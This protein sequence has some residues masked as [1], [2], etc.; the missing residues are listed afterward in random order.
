MAI[1][2]NSCI[3]CGACTVA[4][5]AENN[6]PVVG[7]TEV[8]RVHEMSWI[9]ID[10]YYSF[11]SEHGTID[12]EKE[13]DNIED[14][15]DI[16]VVFQPMLCQHC[17]NA[18]CENVCPV[19]ATNHSS[20]GPESNGL[21]TVVSERGIAQITVLIKCVGSTGWIIPLL[22]YSLGTNLGR[23]QLLESKTPA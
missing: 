8:M 13:Y 16:Q 3:G 7:K 14:Y 18:P 23:C 9:R 20:E 22:T 6:V 4:C 15:Q 19:N 11:Q 10:R 2:L 12:K 17:D 21:Q 1:D 5:Q